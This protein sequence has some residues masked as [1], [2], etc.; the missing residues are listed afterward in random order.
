MKRGLMGTSRRAILAE[1]RAE[2]SRKGGVASGDCKIR[3]DQEYYRR[4]GE[5]AAQVRREKHEAVLR[6]AG[7][8]AAVA[9]HRHALEV[10][11][12]KRREKVAGGL[13]AALAALPILG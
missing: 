1:A 10:R 6:A 5:K 13:N 2:F 12:S 3:G 8:E 9:R 7:G 11:R 4:I